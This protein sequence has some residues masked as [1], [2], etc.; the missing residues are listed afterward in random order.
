MVKAEKVQEGTTAGREERHEVGGG[1]SQYDEVP[2]I[3]VP[4]TLKIA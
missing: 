1:V 2:T 4:Q 3:K